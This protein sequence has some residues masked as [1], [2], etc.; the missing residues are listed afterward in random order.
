MNQAEFTLVYEKFFSRLEKVFG[1]PETSDVEGFFD[2]YFN[3]LRRFTEAQLTTGAD[4]IIASRTH[5]SWPTAGVCVQFCSGNDPESKNKRREADSLQGVR[6]WTNI[7][8]RRVSAFVH[9][10]DDLSKWAGSFR[11]LPLVCRAEANGWGRELRHA[12]RRAVKRDVMLGLRL[13]SAESYVPRDA[14][15][16]DYA[17]QQATSARLAKAWRDENPNHRA[18]RP[19]GNRDG[20]FRRPSSAPRGSTI[21]TEAT[22]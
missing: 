11:D 2:E 12:V 5:K 10:G 21:R 8:D 7:I 20:K 6:D 16:S 19:S 22:Q 4:R 13:G 14:R 18:I 15:F 9:G 3:A 1:Q 17:E